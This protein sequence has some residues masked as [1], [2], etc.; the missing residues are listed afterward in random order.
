VFGTCAPYK[1]LEVALDAFDLPRGTHPALRLTVAGADHPR[2]PGYLAAVRQRYKTRSGVRWLGYVPPAELRAI[3][4]R[5]TVVVQPATATTGDSGAIY[6]A[7][8]WGR[9]VIA[10]DLAELRA[11]A[12]DVD[13]RITYF[14]AGIPAALA[15]TLRDLLANPLQREARVAHNSEIVQRLTWQATRDA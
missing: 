7:A 8:S 4:A 6:R 3:F 13:P 2:F 11:T 5:A 9:L 1:G 10:S 14:P 12:E 15:A